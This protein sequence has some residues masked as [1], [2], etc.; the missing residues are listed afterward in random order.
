MMKCPNCNGTLHFDIKTQKLKC[1][2]CSGIF[3][4]DEYDRNNSAEESIIEGARLYTCKNCGAQL[5]SANDEAVSYCS[6]CGSE[7]VLESEISGV[8]RPKYIVPFKISKTQCR[9]IYKNKLKG[10][11]Y[12][13]KEFRDPEFIDKFRPFYI[14]YWMYKV[15]FR[16]DPFDI[17]GH[18]SF[19]RG[20]YDYYEEYQIK[21]KIRDNGLYGIP[22]DASRNFDDSIAEQIAPFNKKDMVNYHQGYL[23]G[24]YAD[25]P[26]VDG[27]I[28]KDEVLEKATKVAVDD[29]KTDLGGITPVLPHRKNK[30]QEFLGAEY[31]GED[32]VYLPVWFL[33]WRKGN[34]VAYAVVNGQS[35]KIHIDLPAD[36]NVFM[37]YTVFGAAALFALLTLFVS[38]TSRFII[39]FS[40]MLLYMVGV[41]YHKELTQIRNRE[42]HVFDKGYLLNDAKE[43]P[44]SEKKRSRIRKRLNR[45]GSIFRTIL[46]AF[47]IMIFFMTFLVTGEMYDLM[48]SQTGAIGMTFIILILEA[49]R[50]LKQINVARYLRNKRSLLIC[51]IGLGAVVYAFAVASM[52][53]VEDWWYYLGGLICLAA[54]C[55]MSIDLILRYNETSTRPLPS[56]YTR[57]G[58]NDNA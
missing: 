26:N 29:L 18:K 33:T 53:P 24:M 31:T 14:P 43:L 39:W 34:R 50:F 52:E 15:S 38:V 1:S 30:L 36:M 57:K 10:K 32:T 40:A 37:A 48:V 5:I 11:F 58:G 27:Y 25:A 55:A 17:K 13:P 28:Y 3:E 46:Y 4:V 12:V 45:E 42:N 7:A 41:R 23:A 6:Y 56:F 2:S 49:V 16:S 20:G 21:A 22:Y 19:T 35:G 54:A 8:K 9:N 51:F 47:V 44:M